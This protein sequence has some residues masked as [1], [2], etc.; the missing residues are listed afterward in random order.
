MSVMNPSE[1][2]IAITRTPRGWTVTGEIDA[3]TSELLDDALGDLPVMP[4]GSVEIDLAG[5]T[6][7]DSSGLRVLLGLADR[8]A[9]TGRTVA[10]RNPSHTVIRLL[11]IT[12]LSAAFGLDSTVPDT[13]IE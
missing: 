13:Q 8:V 5:I 3:L 12:K 9:G 6:F 1:E 2:R 4:D 7:I 10:V 11:E